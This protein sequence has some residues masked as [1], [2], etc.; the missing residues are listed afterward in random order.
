MVYNQHMVVGFMFDDKFNGVLL[1]RKARPEWHKGLLNGVGGHCEDQDS[2]TDATMRR[3]FKEETGID[4]DLGTWKYVATLRGKSGWRVWVLA[5][6]ASH[7]ILFQAVENTRD[8]DENVEI[9]LMDEFLDHLD[10]VGNV[11]WL[12]PLAIDRLTN[13]KAPNCVIVDYDE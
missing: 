7:D 8:R 12:V 1:I 13:S 2:G 9:I 3:E 11:R 10:M 6:V 4:T 5:T